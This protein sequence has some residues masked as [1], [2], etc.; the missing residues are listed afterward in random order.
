M[1]IYTLLLIISLMFQRTTS[2]YLTCSIK[3]SKIT[4]IIRRN[5]PKLC[6]KPVK[7]FLDPYEEAIGY[8]LYSRIGS[9][10]FNTVWG[11]ILEDIYNT[12]DIFNKF[13]HD[14]PNYNCDGY[15]EDK[16]LYE[17]KSRYN[18]MKSS[19]ACKEIE[20]KLIKAIKCDR[21]FKLLIL[22]DDPI[23]YPEGR[24]VPLHLGHNLQNINFIENYNPEHD[25]WISG[26]EVY[27]LLW[28]DEHEL[29]KCTIINEL[30]RLSCR[31]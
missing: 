14:E 9:R 30:Y 11:Q 21:E 17:S 3:T 29:V 24:N 23:K 28:P 6:G 12:S 16:I 4:N 25:R 27:K 7:N 18:T 1:S 31:L 20:N 2:L 26:N 22:N 10:N 15:F 5:A 13:Q 19:Y 8:N